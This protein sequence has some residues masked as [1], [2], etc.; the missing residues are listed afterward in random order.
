MGTAGQIIVIEATT[1]NLDITCGTNIFC[2][3]TTLTLSG[4]DSVTF[5]YDGTDWVMIA[6]MDDA[7]DQ[8]GTDLAEWFPT[9]GEIEAAEVV[10]IDDSDPV[11]MQKA[12]Q[13]DGQKVVGVVS[14]QP[15]LIL[16]QESEGVPSALVA[17]VGRVPVK[18]D[19]NSPAINNG[20]LIGASSTAGMAQKVNGDYIIGRALESW[21]PG[22]EQ[23]T[24]TVFVNPIYVP[25]E[26]LAEGT[27]SG[28][29]ELA[30]LQNEVTDLQNSLALLTTQFELGLEA[31]GSATFT[32]LAVTD[33]NVLGD[34]V[35][36]DTVINGSLNV[37]TIQIDNNTNSIDAIGT[38]RIQDLA[39]GDIEF[40]GG[41]I[42]FDT[43]GNVAV[44][45]ITANKYN[46][47]GTSAGTDTIPVNVKKVFV[48]TDQVTTN[49][50]VFVTPKRAIAFPL[51]V[52]DKLDGQ[53]F[54]VEI[55]A[56][57]SIPTQFDWWIVDKVS[58]N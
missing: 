52:T 18:V 1:T 50:L 47:A 56:V 51:S 6:Y 53:G 34:A 44:N 37:G 8:N 42:T 39:L 48:E 13:S 54:Y 33:L 26:N 5:I 28:S 2:G 57:Q 27:A 58:S 24:V 55:P 25:G 32:D 10:S 15:G 46:V 14:T 49:S 45:E 22:T 29:G 11:K 30:S 9:N 23:D 41:L 31:T 35:L 40:M 20:D 3:T 36:G 16:G 21:T 43:E 17:L 38:L 4:D 7:I 12:L 19:P